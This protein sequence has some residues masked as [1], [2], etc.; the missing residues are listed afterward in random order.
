MF[1]GTKKADT[2]VNKKGRKVGAC[3]IQKLT[4]PWPKQYDTAIVSHSILLNRYIF[5]TSPLV[6]A[7]ATRLQGDL[8]TCHAHSIDLIGA[9]RCVWWSLRCGCWPGPRSLSYRPWPCWHLWQLLSGW[10]DLPL[11]TS[12]NWVA[13]TT[14]SSMTTISTATLYVRQLVHHLI[15]I[16]LIIHINHSLIFGVNATHTFIIITV[17]YHFYI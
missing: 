14:H 11:D 9:S 16:T 1:G 8:L 2:R 6:H 4:F 12:R 3:Y 10:L 5:R 17:C 7:L 13:K 15:V